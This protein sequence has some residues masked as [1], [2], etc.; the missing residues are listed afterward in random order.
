MGTLPHHILN[1][2]HQSVFCITKYHISHLCDFQESCLGVWRLVPILAFPS[3]LTANSRT[4]AS[5]TIVSWMFVF[6]ERRYFANNDNSEDARTLGF[7]E[8][9]YFTFLLSHPSN[10]VF[11]DIST[12]IVAKKQLCLYIQ[13]LG[14]VSVQI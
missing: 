12:R 3:I 6:W 13:R 11:M 4:L 5:A 7:H 1:L 8:F 10:T 2:S 14:Y 9:S